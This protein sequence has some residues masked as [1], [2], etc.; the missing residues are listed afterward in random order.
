LGDGASTE[1]VISERA[2][3]DMTAM[4]AAAST[5]TPSST[6]TTSTPSTPKFLMV[7]Q[8]QNNYYPIYLVDEIEYFKTFKPELK[9]FTHEHKIIDIISG[10]V[11]D[12]MREQR[13][14]NKPINLSFITKFT[15]AFPYEISKLYVNR[16]NLCYAVELTHKQNPIYVPIKYS[17]WVAGIPI[18]Y[19]V[20]DP[21][22]SSTTLKALTAFI[23]DMNTYIDN[24]SDKIIGTNRPTDVN[25]YRKITPI[26]QLIYKDVFAGFVDYNRLMFYC[27]SSSS[28]SSTTLF[29]NLPKHIINYDLFAINNTIVANTPETPNNRGKLLGTS[30]YR[31]YLYQ[32]VVVEFVNYLEK[33]RNEKIRSKITAIVEKY[34]FKKDLGEIQQRIKGILVDYP[35]DATVIGKQLSDFTSSNKAKKNFIADFES[36][37]YQ[38][39]KVSLAAIKSKGKSSGGDG[40]SSDG[41]A[42][43]L[44]TSIMKKLVVED[45]PNMKDEFPNVYIPCEFDSA[46]YCVGSKLAVGDQLPQLIDIL[47]EDIF[48]PIKEKYLISSIF[49]NNILQQLKFERVPNEEITIY[50]I[51]GANTEV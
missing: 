22:T 2:R 48:N 27:A 34:D 49:S 47:L 30:L 43:A 41:S 36:S 51:L 42:T 14:M 37:K 6:T 17:S 33:E 46:G 18:D 25:L 13:T 20:Y 44:L 32:L 28:S 19:G 29:A 8:K 23:A 26:M 11:M 24:V 12:S 1:L 10:M 9:L 4:K 50:R 38:F 3:N 16:R 21:A 35:E 45:P 15:K 40:G 5:D 39:D 7:L 31:N